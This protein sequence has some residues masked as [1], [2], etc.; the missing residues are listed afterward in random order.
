MKIRKCPDG[1][2]TM[3]EICRCGKKAKIAHPAKF[4]EKYGKYRRAAKKQQ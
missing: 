4:S 1:H 3:N 2:Y